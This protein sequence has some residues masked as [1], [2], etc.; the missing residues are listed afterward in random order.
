VEKPLQ[1]MTLQEL[2]DELERTRSAWETLDLDG[3]LAGSELAALSEDAHRHQMVANE[4]LR[5]PRHG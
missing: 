3:V 2:R 1:W 5:R 4:L